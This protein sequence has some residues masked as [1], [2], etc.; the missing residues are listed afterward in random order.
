MQNSGKSALGFSVRITIECKCIYFYFRDRSIYCWF[1]QVVTAPFA[2][3]ADQKLT[4]NFVS[5]LSYD[6]FILYSSENSTSYPTGIRLRITNSVFFSVSRKLFGRFFWSLDRNRLFPPRSSIPLLEN[7]G[8]KKPTLFVKWCQVVTLPL[9]SNYKLR[10]IIHRYTAI[11]YVRVH[12]RSPSM[13]MQKKKTI[14][15][16]PVGRIAFLQTI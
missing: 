14:L 10:P 7:A 8:E 5:E 11:L 6:R 4:I 12:V 1:S 3:R 15:K 16:R 2:V 13:I 9:E